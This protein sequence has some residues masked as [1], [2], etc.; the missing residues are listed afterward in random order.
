MFVFYQAA[1]QPQRPVSVENKTKIISVYK[2][3]NKI[4]GFSRFSLINMPE[5]YSKKKSIWNICLCKVGNLL[6]H[7]SLEM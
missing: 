3:N 7:D 2:N 5:G 6:K 4:L 1:V